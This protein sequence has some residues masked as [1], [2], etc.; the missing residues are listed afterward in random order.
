MAEAF[1][2]VEA[3]RSRAAAGRRIVV[4]LAVAVVGGGLLVQQFER[5]AIP[6]F[7]LDGWGGHRL[8]LTR[9]A[10]SMCVVAARLNGAL[11]PGVLLD[12]GA[13]GYVTLGRNHAKRAGFD[14]AKL[15]FNARYGSANGIGRE[16]H[17]RLREFRLEGTD[18]VLRDAPAAITA[19][20]QDQPL[21]GIEILS[22]LGMHLKKRTCE[23]RW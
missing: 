19:A 20:P 14:P 22:R 2:L 15:A 18:F 11:F 17:V 7:G 12:S 5:I 21:A 16:A 4:S 9:D 13:A 1:V 8:V 23:L 10:G 3:A 6:D